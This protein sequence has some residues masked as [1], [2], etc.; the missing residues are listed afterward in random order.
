VAIIGEV[1]S[2]KSSLLQAILNNM[3]ITNKKDTTQLIVNGKVSYV[4]QIPWIQNE[5]VRENI[6]FNSPYD[7][8]K[9]TNI[10]D[11]CE[12][13]SD[14]DILIGGDLTEIGE[15]G[16]NLSGGQKARVS[17]ARAIYSDPDIVILDDPI[18][19]LDAHVGQKIMNNVIFNY[20]N[21]KTRILVTLPYSIS[22]R[23]IR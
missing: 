10:L 12:L 13:K 9:Y 2:G 18:S 15:K 16:V 11:L 14:L 3:L 19:A 1:G 6:I 20:L 8:R 23:L 17:I 4:A 5:T 21:G 22:I 7:E